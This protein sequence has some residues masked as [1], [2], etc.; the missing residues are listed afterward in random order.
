MVL[1]GLPQPMEDVDA[2]DG[3]AGALR[4]PDCLWSLESDGVVF[5]GGG[6]F[7]FKMSFYPLVVKRASFEPENLWF[8]FHFCHERW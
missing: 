3:A 4:S 7:Y 2:A 8:D 1:R 5:G 6:G